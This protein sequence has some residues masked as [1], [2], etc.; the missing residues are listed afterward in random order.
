MT[1]NFMATGL[2]RTF[3]NGYWTTYGIVGA[4][5]QVEAMTPVPYHIPSFIP[6][7][8]Q[9]IPLCGKNEKSTKTKPCAKQ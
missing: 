1:V 8:D 2:T 4:Y 5:L 7:P 9:D 3:A 6:T